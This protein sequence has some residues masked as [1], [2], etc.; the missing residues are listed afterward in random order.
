VVVLHTAAVS[1]LTA[2][3]DI[4]VGAGGNT[5]NQLYVKSGGNVGIGTTSPSNKL[6]VAN[7]DMSI[8][9][10]YSFIL[11]DTD[12]NWRLGRNIIV[13]NGNQLTANTMQFIAA[14]AANEGWQFVDDDGNT[15]F[16]IG[17]S[18]GNA[19]LPS[20][21]LYLN[22]NLAATQSWVTSQGYL[23]SYTETDTLASVT[24]RGASTS[25]NSVFTGGLQ[26]RKNQ[27]DNNYTTAA[28]WTE[29]FGNTTTGIAF[30]ISG[31]VGKF[32]EMR[33]N[34][35]LYWDNA[36]VW[37][38]GNDGSGSGLDADLLDGI[39][40]ARFIYGQSGNRRGTNLISNWN[41]TD[42]PDVAFLSAEN[43]G[44][45][46][47]TS[48]YTYGTQY[49]FHRSGA[50]YRTQLVTALYSS[51]TSIYVRNSRDSDVWTSWKRL[52]HSGDFTSTNI[53]NWNT[54]YG[55]GN[56]ASQGYATQTY[57]NTAISN[58][59]DAA[60]AT[61]DTLNELAAALGDD[62]NFATTVATS[63]GTKLPLA[64]GTMTGS[65]D[66]GGNNITN[67]GQISVVKTQDNPPSGV[68]G[69]L[70]WESDTGIL[71][72]YYGAASAWIDALPL[73]DVTLFYPKAGGAITGDVSI[74][75][76]LTVT[77]NILTSGTVTATGGNSTQWNTAFG[78]G[79][80]ASAGYAAA[81]SLANYLPLAGGTMSGTLNFQQPVGLGFANG[82][83]IKD[84]NLGG[85]II[86]SGA[87][88]N[89]NGTSITI[90][91]N[92]TVGGWLGVT[93][94]VSA[95]SR[96]LSLGILD[97]NSGVTPTQYKI[98]TSIPWNYGGSDFTVNIK[99]FRYG[100]GQMVSLS[101]GW[102]Y[103]NNEFYN[104]TAISNGAWAP[105]ISLAKSP[106]GYVIIYI[107]GPDYWP[108]LYV[109]SV[110]SSNSADLY[111][112]GWSWSDAD[113]SDC[114]LIQTVP[115]GALA[116]N[117][118][119]NAATA[120]NVAYS[121][122]T[123][124]VPT[125]N[126]NTTGNAATSSTFSTGRTN[127]KGVTDNA[128]AGQL[129]W[130]NY[131][132]AHTIFDASNSTSPSGGAV[133]NANSQIAWAGTYPTLMG[134]NGS[135]TYGVRVDSAR[136]ADTAGAL[137]SMNISQFT[138]N[139]GYLTSESDTLATVTARG[140]TTT[141]S[142]TVQGGQ[143]AAETTDGFGL[144]IM[145]NYTNGQ[146]NHRL[147]KFDKGGGVPLYVQLTLGAANVWSNS[148]RFGTYTGNGYEFEVY[149]A[150]KVNGDFVSTG[151]INAS[152]GNSSNWNTAY[153]WGNHA[154]AGYITSVAFDNLTSKS[155]GTGT[156]QTSGDFRAPIFYDSQDTGYY[157]D[158]NSTSNLYRANFNAINIGAYSQYSFTLP[159]P[160]ANYGNGRI[161][162]RLQP[163][164][165]R[166]VSFKI[167]IS[168]TWN[169]AAAFG[170]ISADVSYYCDGTNIYY[171]QVNITSA[172]GMAL[173]S[174]ALGD[175][176]IENGYVS[177]PVYSSN[178]NGI[179]VKVE[180]SPSFDFST[181]SYSSY[182][183][184]SFPG[185][186]TV[187][188]PGAFSVGD[189]SVLTTATFNVNATSTV[190]LT[191]A[192]TNASM[193]K[194]GAG[195]ELYIGGNNTWQMRFNG[196]NVLMDNG[197]YLQNDQSLRAPIFYDSNNTDFYLDPNGTSNL[198][199]LSTLTMAYNGM[200][201]MSANSDYV[202]RYNGSAGYRNGTMGIG[203][204]DFN[205]IFS[206]WGSGFIDSWS[207]PANAPGGSTHYI[208]L[209]SI[210]YSE[211]NTN[212]VY[213][214]QMACAGEADNRF[215]WR[216][217]WPSKRAWVEM[218]H[219]GT[220]GSQSVSYATTAGS[221]PNASNLN[222]SYG[223]TAGAGNGLKF[224][225]GSDLYKIHMG[226]S[227][228][229]HYGPVTD[230]S[231]KT[232][233]DS[234]GATRGFTWG[235]D[236]GT[237]IA[238][239][240]VG[241]G[242][243]QIAGT[244]TASNFSG[245]SSGTNT[246]DQTNISGNA[247][248]ATSAATL[249]GSST[250][251]G[252]LTLNVNWGVSPYT[253][254]FNIVGTHPSMV[255][256]GS[257]GDT[258]Y[259]IHMDSAGDIQYYFGPGY[260]TNNWTQRYTFTKGGNFSVLTG[261]ISA[262]G[263]ITGSNLSGTNTGDQTNITGN[264]G[265]ATALQTGRTLT[266]GSTGKT[267]DGTGN[268]SWTLGEIGAQ[269]AGSY[270]IA[271]GTSAG[272]IDA[273]WGQSF[274]TF[275]PIPSGTPPLQSPNIRT[276]NIGDDYN[277]RTQLAFDYASDVAYFRRRDASGWFTWREFI[278]S[279]NIGSQTVATAGALSSMNISQFTNNSGYITGYTETDTLGTVT[280]RGNSTSQN[281]VFSNG[282]KGLVGVYDAAQT[283]AIFAMGPAYVLTDGGASGT[284]GS[285]YGLAWSYNPDYGGAG[286][287]PQSKAGLNHQLL[288]MQNGVTTAAMGSGIW[289]SGNIS[290]A[291]FSGSSSG[292]NTGDQT[293]ISGNAATA[294]TAPS[295]INRGDQIHGSS[296]VTPATSFA[297][298]PSGMSGFTDNWAGGDLPSGMSHV[299]GIAC[300]HFNNTS[301]SWGWH[302]VGQYDQPGDLRVRWV[303]AGTWTAYY[304][305]LSSSNY[306]SY[307]PT[308]TGTGA[309]GTWAINISGNA[310][311][312][313]SATNL[314]GLGSIQSTSTG[315][316]YTTNY[317]VRENSGGGSNTNEIYAPQLAF[318][319][320]G[321]VA[322]SIMM[323][324]SGRMAIRNN[325][326]SS[327]ENFIAA[328]VYSYGYGDSTQWNTAYSWGNHASAGYATAA[329][330]SGYVS[331]TNNSSLN[332]DS[333]NTRGVTRLYRRDDNSDYSVQTYWTGTYWK[334]EGYSGDNYHAGVS[335]AHA[336]LAD[337]AT[338]AN[339]ANSA[340]SA[341]S[342]SSATSATSAT[343]V[344]T[345]QDNPPAGVNGKL[346]WESDTG[347]L[348]VYY[349]TS[350]AWVDATPVPDMSLYYAK[351]GGP[352]SGD[353]AIQQTLT[354]V[355]NTLIQ[356]TL[357]ETS[358]IS[359]KENI[360]PL[361]SS[362]DKV[363]KLKGV[364]FNKKATPNVKEIGFIAQEVE[365]VIPDLVTETNEG[366]KTVSYSRVTAVLVE[367]IKEQQ[368]Q[369]DAQQFQIEELK[370]M[371]NLLAEK[372]NNL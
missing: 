219:S 207:S 215:F 301:N 302:M 304:Q 75:Q 325:P 102:H 278:H 245:T 365:A 64:G 171:P 149:G 266:I 16:E 176:V 190:T 10:G 124:T 192:G 19:W 244:F 307:S 272:N 255:F 285:L 125:W 241:N 17:A 26:A 109:E 65:I 366:I 199:K 332:S 277:R 51:D 89:I 249:T 154:S 47:P 201:P 180:G 368:A 284:I 243:M 261:N 286:N 59:V 92:T 83:Y 22:G 324:A 185:P 126:Q 174:L 73:P 172:T 106:D 96:K 93:G 259:L 88:V 371:V 2:N 165:T 289:T 359:L 348:K 42:F 210:H 107:P 145:G 262:S 105:T 281:I 230:Y 77:G 196:G 32:L 166:I 369:I 315:T 316:S 178:S 169:W 116:T 321:V 108:K 103:Y 264:S 144:E 157:V 355:G 183:S 35:V 257:N 81:S 295:G 76:S 141:G 265:T 345:I 333:R 246:G 331:T 237:P 99:G 217:S 158:P 48:D 72:V 60:P 342:A 194:A 18:T 296:G 235:V 221:A 283:Q 139:S 350:S 313:S 136:L 347:K 197:G 69:Q 335:V 3:G 150:A 118:S 90:S 37:T 55:W 254:A 20:G 147:A 70:W 4:V 94:I 36:Q 213:G 184:V 80:H 71:K 127:Y 170:Y 111:T 30:H 326:G 179:D 28:L 349:G 15:R 290:A 356:G 233:I 299:H 168:S 306:N 113:L 114:T 318:H 361:E 78:W 271:N 288:L 358:D 162:I 9:T 253:A 319:W 303:N 268:V 43:G 86:Y 97:L 343:V 263:T 44:T 129:M 11:A 341:S 131:G 363:M 204:T 161:Y 309:S 282:R 173:G 50:A 135:E 54:A 143:G 340:G 242:N 79:N 225:G 56:H 291:N 211:L 29:S 39:D 200:N 234:N 104:R 14:N 186:N 206:N 152:G 336:G 74:L 229:Y 202:G 67:I 121:G 128:V 330:L 25:T 38:A 354:V 275:D 156:Y 247:A 163:I 317:Q 236:G 117:I 100:S 84:N 212:T 27:T 339:Y 40:S 372:L 68:N 311:T 140:N 362:L 273:D 7:G 95:N 153:G 115:Y 346:W 177:L 198:L 8:T 12:T 119:G 34:G 123:G 63:I 24:A 298:M 91:N 13:E 287:N 137:T 232:N 133:N 66:M 274:K 351:A 101:I 175:L 305:L 191:S 370:N 142:I 82:Q 322:S 256:R 187:N 364:S 120:T 151:Q 352:I 159:Y 218:I 357:T 45:N 193:I 87:A 216:S 46:A 251:N 280:N 138:N 239:L 360:L 57:V 21:N 294:T 182:A 292:T 258:H 310:A 252:Y 188:I 231:I 226:N 314:I 367:T 248:T 353:V 260:T 270:V 279:G 300:R 328:V 227:A 214:F 52:W 164:Q 33:T 155:S 132:N 327:Y 222:A 220:I 238:A 6:Q 61:L 167:K 312:A 1:Y 293:N 223:V 250:V 344:V 31:N 53:S 224:W 112:S 337:S 195:D 110:Y 98:K 208:G 269:A 146:Y 297:S 130:K 58:L 189:N 23:T 228:E 338:N 49:S 62:P 181:I 276:I 160:G 209:Q 122:L 329:S 5:T 134:W 41:Q 203:N 267:F 240:N 308:L 323:E 320:S 85:L 334:L 148:A 205:T